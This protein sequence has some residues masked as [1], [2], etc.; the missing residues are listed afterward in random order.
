M[1][2]FFLSGFH[3]MCCYLISLFIGLESCI[4]LRLGTCPALSH[5]PF[6][7]LAVYIKP[8]GSWKSI[9]S[10]AAWGLL[11]NTERLDYSF[12]MLLAVAVLCSIVLWTHSYN[13]TDILP[14]PDFELEQVSVRD[15]HVIKNI[16]YWVQQ[17]ETYKYCKNEWSKM[18][19]IQ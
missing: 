18:T 17:T 6:P 7:L 14:Q 13:S 3:G 10:F 16:I 11:L 5:E 2:F 19:R 12:N 9:H 15:M 8:P 4:R 1:L